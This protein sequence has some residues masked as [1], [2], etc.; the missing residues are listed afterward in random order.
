MQR[1][2]PSSQLE[3]RS[4]RDELTTRKKE[5]EAVTAHALHQVLDFA[6]HRLHPHVKDRINK[7]LWERV[8]Q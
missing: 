8:K 1:N 5:K 4:E 3:G 6:A 2:H 7:T